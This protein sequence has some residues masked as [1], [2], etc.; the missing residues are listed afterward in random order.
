MP[1]DPSARRSRLDQCGGTR[2]QPLPALYGR[3]SPTRRSLL[4]GRR[5]ARHPLVSRPHQHP[6]IVLQL[7]DGALAHNRTQRKRYMRTLVFSTPLPRPTNHA[8]CLPR[9][10][11]AAA[12][13]SSP[14]NAA[15]NVVEARTRGNP[16]SGYACRAF[17][18]LPCIPV[19]RGKNVYV[20]L[21]HPRGT[22][23]QIDLWKNLV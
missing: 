7:L 22:D 5:T 3:G 1:A 17:P 8:S 18:C 13:A 10:R 16:L 11:N 12:R 21:I 2:L 15:H 6:T 14:R 9:S 20:S 23:T 4:S 19:D